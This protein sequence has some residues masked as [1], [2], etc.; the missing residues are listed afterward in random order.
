[1]EKVL[2]KADKLYSQG[3][4]TTSLDLYR[5][6]I[7]K[8]FQ[9]Y[10][11]E[12]LEVKVSDKEHSRQA[13][14]EMEENI[15]TLNNLI[16]P[17][18][19]TA[20]LKTSASQFTQNNTTKNQK[21]IRKRRSRVTK[22][23]QNVILEEI[24]Q[25]DAA[26]LKRVIKDFNKYA[27]ECVNTSKN[28]ESHAIFSR[29]LK[30]CMAYC[31]SFPKLTCL[32]YNN[33]SCL[34][35]KS[36]PKKALRYLLKALEFAKKDAKEGKESEY[37]PLTYINLSAV[38]SESKQH[39]KSLTC[40]Q[41]AV[42]VLSTICGDWEDESIE[43][44]HL[45][46][47]TK[48]YFSLLAIAYY[49][50]GCQYEFMKQYLDSRL[51]FLKSIKVLK[52]YFGET[53]P[54]IEENRKSLKRIEKIIQNDKPSD[55]KTFTNLD[56]SILQNRI[57]RLME[58]RKSSR[59]SINLAFG[60]N[61]RYFKNDRKL[62]GS[63]RYCT[64]SIRGK[65]SDRNRGMRNH[66]LNQEITNEMVQEADLGS[67][68]KLDQQFD[69]H[70]MDDEYK[71]S[72]IREGRA[73]KSSLSKRFSASFNRPNT[74]SNK[75]N[76]K[77]NNKRPKSAKTAVG[78]T[79]RMKI[80]KKLQN[81]YGDHSQSKENDLSIFNSTIRDSQFRDKIMDISTS[82]KSIYGQN[83][84][85]YREPGKS[86]LAASKIIDEP[87]L[88]K[89][90]LASSS[91]VNKLLSNC[92]KIYNSTSRRERPST[93]SFSKKSVMKK[94][95]LQGEYQ[96]IKTHIMHGTKPVYTSLNKTSS[97]F[98]KKC[99]FK[100]YQPRQSKVCG[101]KK[102]LK[103]SARRKQMKNNSVRV[104]SQAQREKSNQSSMSFTNVIII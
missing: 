17:N 77:K 65:S 103:R 86:S 96:N 92:S 73:M 28:E 87:D 60:V 23:S 52:K 12:I 89:N 39:K 6:V 27:L 55:S 34:F 44:D 80:I 59:K 84:S 14:Q 16:T 38:Y 95:I 35:K 100:A 64:K 22:H 101:A 42:D 5:K 56:C 79:S 47:K 45:L 76:V 29:L 70:M 104:I 30:M 50:V 24:K 8:R 66:S 49:N 74:Y 62:K 53:H 26:L 11:K 75:G 98:F 97:N 81:A 51:V 78:N 3:Q 25:E 102:V 40:S 15:P 58:D 90:S 82:I 2:Q 13:T 91:D 61:K 72:E 36:I 31:E 67:S 32:T 33:L 7:Q 93:A 83:N 88:M 18:A 10:N 94:E 43:V 85:K 68:I 41:K 20:G 46:D 69:I 19:F 21:R 48:E 99:S 9:C 54:L 57:T 37:L 4:F 1:M 63:R 71:L